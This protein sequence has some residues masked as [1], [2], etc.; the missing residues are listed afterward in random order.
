MNNRTKFHSFTENSSADPSC[1][2]LL[3]PLDNDN[4]IV[5]KPQLIFHLDQASVHSELDSEVVISAE[6]KHSLPNIAATSS[7]SDKVKHHKSSLRRPPS[8][9]PATGQNLSI[10]NALVNTLNLKIPEEASGD[11]S[12]LSI[13]FHED[14]SSKEILKELVIKPR[15]QTLSEQSLPDQRSSLTQSSALS[16]KSN[17]VKDFEVSAVLLICRL[18][19]SL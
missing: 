17:S 1:T 13:L 9:L 14:A 3:A 12:V 7:N 8:M 19:V 4:I 15:T 10:S 5:K 6:T 2:S 11:R 16:E 18:H